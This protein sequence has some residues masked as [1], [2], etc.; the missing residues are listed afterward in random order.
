MME[1]SLKAELARPDRGAAWLEATPGPGAMNRPG[2]PPHAP[3]L[4]SLCA[5]LPAE[6]SSRDLSSWGSSRSPHILRVMPE[7]KRGRRAVRDGKPPLPGFSQRL[8]K[9]AFLWS[10][11]AFAFL[12]VRLTGTSGKRIHAEGGCAPKRGFAFREAAC[13][14]SERSLTPSAWSHFTGRL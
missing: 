8:A 1:A 2:Q 6:I 12:G 3:R 4:S 13:E 7:V 10:H 14:K 5:E 11:R 9:P